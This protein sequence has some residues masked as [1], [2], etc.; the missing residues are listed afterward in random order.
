MILEMPAIARIAAALVVALLISFIATPVVKSLAH[1][2]GAIDVPKDNRRMH[3]HPIPRMGG[4]AIFLG[5]LLSALIFV[6]MDEANRGMLLGAVVIVILGIFDDIYALPAL[7]KL[8]VQIAAALI[9]VLHGNVIQV[10]SN[11]NLLSENPYWSLGSLAIPLSVIWIVAITNAVNLI[12]G[13]DGLAVGVATISSLTMLVIAMLVSDGMVALMMAALAGGCI[14]FMPYNMNPAKIFMGDTGSTFL[15]FVLAV[16]SIQGLFKFYTIISFAVP[17]LMLGLP[18]FDTCFAILRRLAKG[19][20]PMAP[21]RSHVHHRLIDM[22]FSQ[23]QAVAILYV[24]SAILGLSAVVLTTSGALKAMVLLCALCLA[25]LVSAKIFLSHNDN[26]KDAGKPIE[27]KKEE[28]SHA[29]ESD[30]DL[31]D[32]PGGGEDGPSGEGTGKPG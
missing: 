1:W 18:L 20:S 29:P 15:G 21:D 16:V 10:L 4:L 31:R 17:F 14:G 27:P 23:K 12:D 26:G 25:G 9:A 3:K 11:P 8:L 13:L 28:E 7:P 6:P 22:G 24:V 32:P 5:F 19:Q 30:D 2:V